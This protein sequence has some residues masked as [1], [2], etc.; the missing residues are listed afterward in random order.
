M[1]GAG[2]EK[3]P[4]CFESVR[5]GFSG[6]PQR[7][8]W[9]RYAETLYDRPLTMRYEGLDPEASYTVKV[10]YGT[11]GMARKVRLTAGS[12]EIHPWMLKPSPARPL[13]FAI[14]PQGY[15]D[16]KLELTFTAEPGAGG[17]GRCC[18]VCEVWVLRR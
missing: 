8:S 15:A 3:D 10:V 9:I 13:E 18:Q 14:P 11:D 12:A 4:G 16:G 17:N 5:V 1:I 2:F 7:L 6:N